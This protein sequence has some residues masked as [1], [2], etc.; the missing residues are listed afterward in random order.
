[1]S[2]FLSR[3]KKSVDEGTFNSEAANKIN[4][5]SAAAD[6]LVENLTNDIIK[7][8]NEGDE[9]NV[10]AEVLISNKLVDK[11]VKRQEEFKPE[12]VDEKTALEKN[13]EAERIML[14]WEHDDKMVKY[15]ARIMNELTP[16]V[17]NLMELVEL[18]DQMLVLTTD[19]GDI[20]IKEFAV[21]VIDTS[22]DFLANI[23]E[24][25]LQVKE[26]LVRF[27]EKYRKS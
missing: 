16:I 22:A 1:M 27:A 25:D 11:L 12:P 2:D 23:Y 18:T 24:K 17:K 13:I 21:N 15:Q 20:E 3:L 19:D 4:E 10:N 8:V 26:F 6:K 5:I 7:E 14:K 9:K